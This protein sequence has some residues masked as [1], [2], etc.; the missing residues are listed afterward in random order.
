MLL[1][2]FTDGEQGSQLYAAAA[3]REQA[4]LI[5]RH[6]AGMVAREPE[7]SKRAKI[8]KSM[9]S[10]EFPRT[11]SHFRALASD[12]DNL[13]GLNVQFVVVDELH[14]HPNAELVDVLVTAT[15]SRTQPLVTYITTADFAR[16]SVCN[17]KHDYASKVRDGALQ[18]ASF[19]P[20]IYEALPDDDWT[21]PAVWAKANPNLGVSVKLEYLDRQCRRAMAVPS[22]ENTFRRLH[23]NQKTSS[24]SRWLRMVDWHQCG[25]IVD[26]E[27]LR[28]RRCFGGL[29]L[30]TKIDLTAWVL[31]FVEDDGSY[32]VLPRFFMPAD[33]ARK[34]EKED[35]VPYSLWAEQGFLEL[36]AGNVIDHEAVKRRILADS[37]LYQ[38]EEIGFD[39]WSATQLSIELA[40][41][42]ATMTEVRQGFRS[43]SE[44]A[45]E[46]EKL[47]VS[48][49][50]SHGNHPVLAA[51][52]NVC[53]IEEDAAGNIKP[54]KAKSTDRIDGV[55]AL[56]MALGRAMHSA[57]AVKYEVFWV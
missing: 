34:R 24:D 17:S 46:L 43:F 51:Q 10:I 28:G 9:K 39:P 37:A 3:S 35:R 12:A 48:G 16:E 22:Y 32:T 50:L 42:G 47:V 18:D 53:A 30:S 23:L 57:P 26:P 7:L 29:D 15:G 13:H 44:P 55:V 45:K 27:S 40:S 52:A 1:S 2:A 36:T 6:A 14:S 33:N 5:F 11:G 31:V 4:T 19:L 8:Y 25:G 49:K 38:I 56:C 21:S 41:E 20:V 54:S